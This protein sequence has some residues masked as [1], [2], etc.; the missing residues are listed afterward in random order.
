VSIATAGRENQPSSKSLS[1][2]VRSYGVDRAD[3]WRNRL[4]GLFTR[5]R[6]LFL[7]PWYTLSPSQGLSLERQLLLVLASRSRYWVSMLFIGAVLVSVCGTHRPSVWVIVWPLGL[8]AFVAPYIYLFRR[9]ANLPA[10]ATSRAV[11]QLHIMWIILLTLISIWWL[12][13]NWT[14]VVQPPPDPSSFILGQR[15]FV[16]ITFLCQIFTVVFLSPSQPAILSVLVIGVLVPFCLTVSPELTPTVIHPINKLIFFHAHILL[17]CLFG[18]I[19]PRNELRIRARGILLEAERARAASEHTRANTFLS[20]ISHDLRQPLAA[21]ALKLNSL[22]RKINNPSLL[23]DVQ[24]IQQ[25]AISIENMVDGTLNLSRLESGT[26]KMQVREVALPYLLEGVVADLRSE[27]ES[28]NVKI[29]LH[30]LPYLVRTDPSALESILRN[31]IG[32]AI[33]YTPAKEGDCSKVIIECELRDNESQMCISVIDS[34]FGIPNNRLN[35]IFKEYVQLNNPARDRKKGLGLG[36]SIVKGLADLLGHKL[37]V[38]SKEGSGSSFSVLVPIIARIPPELRTSTLEDTASTTPDLTGMVVVLIENDQAPGEALR[39]YLSEWGCHVIDGESADDVIKK[40]RRDAVQSGPHYILSDLRLIEGPT[41]GIDAIAAIREELK[42]CI[43]AAIWSA[44]TEPAVLKRVQD[45]GFQ[46]L[47]KPIDEDKLVEL[48]NEH[49]P[50][51]L[52]QS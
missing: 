41:A 9:V 37:E 19:F 49:K 47:S 33:R 3:L 1:D 7:D 12:F 24:T 43:P 16:Y 15:T 20:A 25:Q 38:K 18:L 13:G 50:Y 40:L 23:A 51:E 26:W 10:E 48:L 28:T 27:V 36:L 6:N 30:S 32:N 42:M 17:Y 44:E 2:P 4:T 8:V 29:E 5:A 39:D 34:G 11:R 46:M 21:V 35:E 14:L 22:K 52:S 31:L 45:S